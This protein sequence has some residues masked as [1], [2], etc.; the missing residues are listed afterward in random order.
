[1][2]GYQVHTL[3]AKLPSV[4]ESS[5]RWWTLGPTYSSSVHHNKAHQTLLNDV[6]YFVANLMNGLNLLHTLSKAD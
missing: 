3:L 1:M 5:W 6:F 2:V 4:I